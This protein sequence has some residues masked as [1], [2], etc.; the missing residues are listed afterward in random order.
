MALVT[1]DCGA[2]RSPGHQIALITSG[3]CALQSKI[4][5]ATMI[6]AIFRGFLTR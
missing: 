6:Q 4:A 3:L 5:S 1:S 2:T